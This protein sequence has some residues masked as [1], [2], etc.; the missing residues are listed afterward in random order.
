MSGTIQTEVNNG[1]FGGKSYVT[2]LSESTFHIMCLSGNEENNREYS[3][4]TFS[5]G[6]KLI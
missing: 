6:T 1:V 5:K 4:L 3:R 2:G